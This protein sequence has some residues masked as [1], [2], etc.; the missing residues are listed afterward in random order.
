MNYEVKIVQIEANTSKRESNSLKV[1]I[2][3]INIT[4]HEQQLKLSSGMHM[5]AH[6]V[7]I[8]L[9]KIRRCSVI[10]VVLLSY[11]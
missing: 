7:K 3:D 4:I 1:D 5:K 8:H 6:A 2:T 10:K 9:K 11:S